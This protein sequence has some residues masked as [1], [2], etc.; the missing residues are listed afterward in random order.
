MTGRSA[1]VFTYAP[2][3]FGHSQVQ[4]YTSSKM[5]EPSP[6]KAVRYGQDP[7]LGNEDA[8]TDVS[9]GL[10]LQGALPRPPA[11]PA[12]PAPQDPLAHAGGGAAAAVC[13]DSSG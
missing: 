7:S 12:G 10:A 13:G 8:A 11:R 6:F 5:S 4:A 3:A 2:C 9:A 1:K